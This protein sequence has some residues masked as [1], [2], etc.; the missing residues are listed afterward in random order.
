[1]ERV[2]QN[3]LNKIDRRDVESMLKFLK[4]SEQEE[5]FDYIVLERWPAGKIVMK[6]GDPGDFMGFVV[7]GKLAV[8]KEASSTGSY[9]LVATLDKGAMVG[10]ASAFGA[11]KRT[12][13]VEAMEDS[14]LIILTRQKLDLLFKNNKE[15]GVKIM[16]RILHVLNMRLQNADDRL[17][18]L[19]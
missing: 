4:P 11:G 7:E 17:A 1:M 2:K 9:I 12:A 19:L 18:W 3:S 13:T 14:T 6:D 15:L 10:E 8:K 16:K 5:L